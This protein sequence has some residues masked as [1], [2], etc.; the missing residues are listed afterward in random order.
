MAFFECGSS[1]G[2]SKIVI[3]IKGNSSALGYKLENPNAGDVWS[4]MKSKSFTLRYEISSDGTVT[5]ISGSPSGSNQGQDMYTRQYGVYGSSY[6]IS[7]VSV[8]SIN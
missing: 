7:S 6:N 5:L 2:T 4:G 1:K 8:I 3:E